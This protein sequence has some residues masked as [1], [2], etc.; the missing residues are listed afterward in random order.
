MTRAESSR[1]ADF[2]YIR[3]AMLA[4]SKFASHDNMSL[5]AACK[6]Y[7]DTYSGF[8]CCF[9]DLREY[10]ELLS[11]SDRRDCLSHIALVAH[12]MDGGLAS[13]EVS[14]LNL[15]AGYEDMP[16]ALSRP[17]YQEA[18]SAPHCGC[19]RLYLFHINRSRKTYER[20]PTLYTQCHLHVGS[21]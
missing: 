12:D 14:N 5:L 19:S 20:L 9:G 17:Q 18:Y 3:V 8:Y 4:F 16:E 11:S 15:H 13:D 10:V 7:F 6:S 21:Y 2:R 1:P